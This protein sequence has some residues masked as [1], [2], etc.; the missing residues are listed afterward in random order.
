MIF[1]SLKWVNIE[2]GF[3]KDMNS[4]LL[5]ESPVFHLSIYPD[6]LPTLWLFVMEK[7]NVIWEKISFP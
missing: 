5:G 6:V 3:P 1:N 4:C 2:F 7:T